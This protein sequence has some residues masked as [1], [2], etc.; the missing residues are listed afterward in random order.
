[1]APFGMSTST[2]VV[3]A[4]GVPQAGPPWIEEVSD[5]ELLVVLLIVATEVAADEVVLV[6]IGVV[7]VETLVDEVANELVETCELEVELDTVELVYPVV[8]PVVDVPP[9][10]PL[11]NA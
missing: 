8:G 9:G 4:V 1:M 11:K 6:L 3:P 7:W 10:E 2:I 5:E